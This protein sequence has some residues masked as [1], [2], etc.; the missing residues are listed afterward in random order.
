MLLLL[1][2]SVLLLM[3]M[4]QS[5]RQ[6]FRS[7]GDC[8]NWHNQR[9]SRMK[10]AATG[11]AALV[12]VV[13]ALA[14]TA[15]SFPQGGASRQYWSYWKQQHDCSGSVAKQCT[16]QKYRWVTLLHMCDTTAH[17]SNGSAAAGNYLISVL[18]SCTSK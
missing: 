1:L 6:S 2:L 10:A 16:S 15:K 17:G 8:S 3:L 18:K 14:V 9:Y 7:A 11:A 12:Y 5:V 13:A 4:L